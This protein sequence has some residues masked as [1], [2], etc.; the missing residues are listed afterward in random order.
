[1]IEWYQNL[2]LRWKVPLRAVALAFITATIISSVLLINLK[3]D[4]R[5]DFLTYTE[6]MLEA[7]ASSLIT[8]LHHQDTWRA[9]E[10][11]RA[12]KADDQKSGEESFLKPYRITVL[13]QQYKVFVSTD[14]M[15]FPVNSDMFGAPN[16]LQI[17]LNQVRASE[18]LE[19]L[20]QANMLF[21][22]LP[23]T[24]NGLHLGALIVEYNTERLAG[25]LEQM[26]WRALLISLVLLAAIL[27][28]SWH[29]GR[30]FADP[31][32]NLANCMERIG[33]KQN[34]GAVC[35]LPSGKDE[36]GRL[37]N[38]FHQ[39]T[40]DM[41]EKFRLEQRLVHGERMAALGRMISGIAHEVNNPLGGMLNTI[42]TH[43]KHANTDPL[44]E[45]TLNLL[46]R[47][48][49]QIRN[50]V[51]AL[52]VEAKIEQRALSPDDVNDVLILTSAAAQK[53]QLTIILE[54]ELEQSLDLPA[55]QVRQIL[56]NLLLNAIQASFNGTQIFCR[57]L[58][59]ATD[60]NRNF[61]SMRVVNS[62]ETIEENKLTTLFEPSFGV[63]THERRGFGL[64]I[65]YQ[66]VTQLNGT[67]EVSSDIMT[68]FNVVLP[69]KEKSN[70]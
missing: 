55:A 18:K 59:E 33:K 28:V 70:D 65:I 34:Q 23:I 10:V 43:R 64:W 44:S 53:K 45:K 21:L 54:N 61:L 66:L 58:L 5:K 48:L 32:I 12:Y 31:L 7:F 2:S 15:T 19:R 13:D 30:R 38:Q 69:I 51:S 42:N 16:E 47:G 24:H 14:P 17:V 36:L 9:F 50:T 6:S 25:R 29:W 22:A 49:N 26:L 41:A 67:I 39:M 68:E 27:V 1:M 35:N 60:D 40:E 3:Q 8:P 4:V 11:V 46:E 37:G 63:E 57:V 62:G 56:I 52:L 20:E